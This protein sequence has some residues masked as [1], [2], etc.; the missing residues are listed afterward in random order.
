MK[1]QKQ[2][3]REEDEWEEDEWDSE[4]EESIKGDEDWEE[5]YPVCGQEDP[6]EEENSD[7]DSGTCGS[8]SSDG[9]DSAGSLNAW[10]D[11]Y[12]PEDEEQV[13]KKKSNKSK[14]KQT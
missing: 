11:T 13:A 8:M 1:Q 4:E 2:Q 7:D 14:A 9:S 5:I 3:K 10:M 12:N 6:S